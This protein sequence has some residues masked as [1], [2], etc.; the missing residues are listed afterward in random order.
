MPRIATIIV[1]L[2]LS[3]V[4]GFFVLWPQY[5]KFSDERWHV[6]EKEAERSNQE[7][8]F[9]HLAELSEELKGYEKELSKIDSAFPQSP[10]IPDLLNF[11]ALTSSQNGLIFKQVNSFLLGSLIKPT[12]ASENEEVPANRYRDITIDFEVSGE[13]FALKNFISALEKSARII[14]IESIKLEKKLGESKEESLSSYNLKI[15]TYYY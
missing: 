10:D 1:C 2:I 13:Y 8:Y 4:L 5:Q 12:P 9:S 3:V 11:L 15:K 6:K 14:E 7:E